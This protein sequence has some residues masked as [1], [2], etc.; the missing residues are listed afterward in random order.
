MYRLC[1]KGWA[2]PQGFHPS[3]FESLAQRH[4]IKTRFHTK[5]WPPIQMNENCFASS[6]AEEVFGPPGLLN[7][8]SLVPLMAHPL[9]S[10]LASRLYIVVTTLILK[11]LFSACA[12]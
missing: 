11:L 1:V 3:V 4:Y 7:M 8:H 5:R 9:S 6:Y 12:V 2:E 10:R